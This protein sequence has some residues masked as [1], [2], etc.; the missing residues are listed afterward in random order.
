LNSQLQDN[1]ATAGLSPLV[2]R[3]RCIA[4]GG[5]LTIEVA[6]T[7]GYPELGPDGRLRCDACEQDYPIVGGTPR[8][9]EPA[10][11]PRLLEHYPRSSEV[12]QHRTA[13]YGNHPG[14]DAA[15]KQRT[16]DSFAYEWRH[17]G[18]PRT[19]WDR[20]FRDYLQ[21]HR[22][23]SLSG[24]T[25]IDVGAGSGRH[26]RQAAHHGAEVVA[27]DLGRSIDVARM[28]LPREVLTVQ[29]DLEN[30]PFEEGSFDFAVSIGVLHHLPDPV[31]GL[32]KLAR[33]AR[34]GGH[35]HV[36]LYWIPELWWHRAL[37]RLV[38][39]ARLV[40]VRLPHQLLHAL[41]YPL[42]AL[43]YAF[44]VVPYRALRARPR[45]RALAAVLPLKTYADYPFAVLVN[46]QFDR[47]SAPLEQ[48]FTRQQV[49]TILNEAGLE[50]VAVLPNHGWVGGGRV[51]ADGIARLDEPTDPPRMSVIVTVRND[52]EGLEELLPALVAQD[53]APDEVVIVD[54]GSV[55]ETLEVARAF[56]TDRFPVR[57]EV[58]PGANIAAGRNVAVS[59]ARNDWVACT[60]AGCRPEPGWLT[61][62]AD[63]AQD[64][65]IVAGVFISDGETPFEQTLGVTHYPMTSEI[66]DP[67]PLVRLSHALFGRRFLARHAG[68]RSMAFSKRVWELA[69][70]FP[71]QQ[72]AGEDLAFAAN[73]IDHG[74]RARLAPEA[75]VHWRPPPSWGANARMFFH[76]CRGDVRSKGRTRHA[77][78]IA[79]WAMTP[80][81]L[82]HG[83]RTRISVGL[84]G[85]AYI[86]LPL[87]RARRS[88]I[89]VREWWR[90][91]LAA[92]VKDLAQVAGAAR[93]FVDAL[94]G[95]PQPTPHPPPP[96]DAV[97]STGLVSVTA[98]APAEDP[99][100]TRSAPDRAD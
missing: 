58:V 42:S 96:P 54:G 18:Q 29:A 94:Q 82:L 28:N 12:L 67:N 4:C 7:A 16:A 59:L 10:A 91:P 41:C 64:A 76:Y 35:V 3:L 57:I 22:P 74:Y 56:E 90:I 73:V 36:Y 37:L 77:A 63:A 44:V 53:T 49:T 26:S 50:D 23:E 81:L 99:A 72:Y 93:G 48:R 85:L 34:P 52:S 80:L 89:A 40:T 38:S 70:G 14:H 17:F 45:G 15:V 19:E 66:D 100:R 60:D 20:N 30:L 97:A 69:G 51:P 95:V 88:G 61:A 5:A 75:K 98:P 33:L 27:V 55:D 11:Q 31:R 9:L 13:E 47:F 24:Q 92:A 1:V 84:S 21:P 39:A 79:A 83:G 71:E 32:R 25:V 62:L 43:L 78:R 6:P 68:G 46:D 8:M 2:A 86:A 87:G 65:D